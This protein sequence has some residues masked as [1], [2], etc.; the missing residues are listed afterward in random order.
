[1]MLKYFGEKSIS[2]LIYNLLIITVGSGSL[3]P[4]YEDH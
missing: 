1:M 2:I 4:L 3:W